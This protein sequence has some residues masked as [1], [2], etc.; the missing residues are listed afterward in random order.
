MTD[1]IG[2]EV[3]VL[4]LIGTTVTGG[5]IVRTA[6]AEA[7]GDRFDPATFDRY[8]GASKHDML[9]A[10]VGPDEADDAHTR[11][12]RRLRAAIEADVLHPLPGAMRC[13]RD[14]KAR[15]I[16]TCLV[17]G[18]S[19]PVRTALLSHLGWDTLVDLALSPEDAG[20]G[21]PAPDLV[22]T[23]ALRLTAS[24]VRAVAVAG[25]TTNDLIAAHRAGSGLRAGVLTGAHDAETLRAAP[26]THILAGIADLIPAIDRWTT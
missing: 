9:A 25:D 5:D 14:L 2:I 12:E 22:L 8:R 10:L 26:H 21:R 7:T 19:R 4:D 15:G 6:T 20:R 16:R 24:D 23:A 13:L 1:R 17:T 18:F 3:A 11:F